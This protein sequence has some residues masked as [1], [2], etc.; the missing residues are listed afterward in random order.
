[1]MNENPVAQILELRKPFNVFHTHIIDRKI[2]DEAVASGK[3]LEIDISITQEGT[4]Y[5]GHPLPHYTA[6]NLP[7]PHNLPLEIIVREAKAAGLFLILDLKDVKTI[8]KAKEIVTV[9][10]AEN[11]LIHAFAKELSFHPWPPKVQAIKGPCWEQEELP[12]DELL[13]LR[14]TTGVP[15]M[16]SCHG[17][18]VERLRHEGD[19]IL[20]RII[21]VTNQEVLSI[22]LSLPPDEDAPLTATTKLIEHGIVPSISLDRTGSQNR[23][24]FFLGFTDHLDRATDQKINRS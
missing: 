3:S 22:G 17:L 4:I 14:E 21:S 1:M 24:E 16:L 12:V 20:D 2:M 11:C 9:Y 5:V 10:G 7:P 23:P 19:H 6:L 18:T 13:R 15:L 8:A